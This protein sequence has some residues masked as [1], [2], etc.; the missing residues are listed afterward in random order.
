M[1]WFYIYVLSD[2]F[3][4][5]IFF[6]LLSSGLLLSRWSSPAGD[7]GRQERV[8]YRETEEGGREDT[9]GEALEICV[10]FCLTVLIHRLPVTYR[11][12]HL[13]YQF[14]DFY[15]GFYDLEYSY[16]VGMVIIARTHRMYRYRYFL[17]T[18]PPP[19]IVFNPTYL[20]NFIAAFSKQ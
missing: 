17:L 15:I 9:P 12:L 14:L 16:A 7:C 1:F 3:F 8:Q 6:I 20:I 19:R 13:L 2:S 5:L 18:P 11:L 4:T 10:R